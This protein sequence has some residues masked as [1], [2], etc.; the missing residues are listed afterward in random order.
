MAG[1][2]RRLHVSITTDGKV[3]AKSSI[4]EIGVT[5]LGDGKPGSMYV[6]AMSETLKVNAGYTIQ[7]PYH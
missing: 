3:G 6:Y 2:L 5:K 7:A 4:L 1:C